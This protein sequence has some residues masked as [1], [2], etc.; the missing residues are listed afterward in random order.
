MGPWASGRGG[1]MSQTLS[2]PVATLWVRPGVPDRDLGYQMG[3]E[4]VGP[5]LPH[6]KAQMGFGNP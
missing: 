3:L 6:I 2:R 4:M 5:R 1:T